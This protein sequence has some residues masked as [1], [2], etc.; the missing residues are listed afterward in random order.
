MGDELTRKEAKRV[1]AFRKELEHWKEILMMDPLWD[2][3]LSVVSDDSKAF[4]K[5]AV[6]RSG[7]KFIKRSFCDL[8]KTEYYSG[9]IGLARSALSVP[10]SEAEH[11]R[12]DTMSHEMIHFLTAD[13]HRAALAAAG[14]DQRVIN[15]LAYRYEQLVVRIAAIVC[16]LDAEIRDEGK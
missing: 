2:I 13:Y 3:R 14:G 9:D 8:S 10:E 11:M 1:R 16:A 5:S 7:K 6:E 4:S 15:E 12:R